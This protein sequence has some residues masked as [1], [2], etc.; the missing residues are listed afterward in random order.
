MPRLAPLLVTLGFACL[1]ARA[2]TVAPALPAPRYIVL[3]PGLELAQLRVPEA[4]WRIHIVRLDRRQPGWEFL[5]TLGGGDA[6]G[7]ATVP[8]QARAGATPGW[9]PWAA[10]NGG[11][12]REERG[13]ARATFAGLL[14]RDGELI[15]GPANTSFWVDATNGLHL[16]VVHSQME[17]T[18]PDGTTAPLG[19]NELPATNRPALITPRYGKHFQLVEGVARELRAS[20]GM[21]FPT[22]RAST[23]YAAVAGPLHL[24]GRVAIPPNA[25]LLIVHPAQRARL[26][27]LPGGAMLQLSTAFSHDLAAARCGLGA[28]PTLLTA[29]VANATFHRPGADTTR[30]PRSAVGFNDRHCFL[31]VVDGRGLRSTGMSYAELARLMIHLG[32]TEAL[33]LDGGT[34]TSL[35]VRDRLV[36]SP[37]GWITPAVAGALVLRQRT[38]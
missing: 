19:L 38:E 30:Q 2:D 37:S 13:P 22:L 11:Y 32:A 35:W 4:P 29:G 20:A 6:L 27:M 21:P 34:S 17:I 1:L 26:E 36:N 16:A 9:M 7:F 25:A 12:F 33:N 10:V 14:I 3:Q 24:T 18:W 8:A 23:N 31:V 28:G 15:S 5:A